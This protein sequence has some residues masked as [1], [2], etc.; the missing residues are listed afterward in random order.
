MR[1]ADFDWRVRLAAGAVAGGLIVY[2]DNFAFAGEVSP[3]VVI[4]LLF[5]VTFAAG[6]MWGLRGWDAA[7]V[8]AACVPLAH[9]AKH[10]LNLPDTLHPNTYGSILSLA[11][12][13][14]LVSAVGLGCGAAVRG[15]QGKWTSSRPLGRGGPKAVCPLSHQLLPNKRIERTP[16]ALS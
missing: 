9:I 10:L 7:L 2:I 11:A 15:L 3:V 6:E 1:L 14:V 12:V 16:R 8:A 4:G 13:C 5:V